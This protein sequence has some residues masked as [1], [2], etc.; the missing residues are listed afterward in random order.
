MITQSIK[1][2]VMQSCNRKGIKGV[3]NEYV[4]YVFIGVMLLLDA[5]S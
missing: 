3:T 5:L 1:I 2:E 4:G